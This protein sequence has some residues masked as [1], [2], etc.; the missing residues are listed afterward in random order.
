MRCCTF[1]T[2]SL[3][4]YK[5]GY[6]RIQKYLQRIRFFLVYTSKMKGI[7]YTILLSLSLPM[8]LRF[9]VSVSLYVSVF[10][11]LSLSFSGFRCLSL[12]VYLSLS[13]SFRFFSMYLSLS[14]HCVSLCLSQSLSVS[15]CIISVFLS[16]CLS[17]PSF[18]SDS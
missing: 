14:D 11:W 1:W 7:Y 15:T 17:M 2:H 12:S 4:R 5:K 18:L 8:S 16:P 13:L 9:F 6:L 10:I 3:G